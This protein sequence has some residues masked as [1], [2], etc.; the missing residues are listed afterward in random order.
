MTKKHIYF[1]LFAISGFSGLVYESIWTHYLKLFLGHAAYAQMLVL[2]IFMGGM[3]LGSYGSTIIGHRF[4]NLL[5]LYALCEACIGVFALVFHPLFVNVTHFSYSFI[6]Q[7]LPWGFALQSY[8]WALSALL[9][10]PQSMLLGATFPLMSAGLLRRYPENPGRVIAKLYFVNSFG[11][12]IGVLACG[13]FL[14]GAL[15]FLGTIIIAGS[16]NCLLA[17]GIALL[18]KKAFSLD[19]LRLHYFGSKQ[20]LDP[21]FNSYA[22]RANSDFFPTLDLQA[23]K[24]AILGR[25]DCFDK[26][27]DL[28][29]MRL[30][31][32]D[33]LENR[34]LIGRSSFTDSTG[35]PGHAVWIHEYCAGARSS[36][37]PP[38]DTAHREDTTLLDVCT[39]SPGPDGLVG[40]S[41]QVTDRIMALNDLMKICFPIL[42]SSE[43]GDILSYIDSRTRAQA[44]PP[45]LR[46]TLDL[47]TAINKRDFETIDTIAAY[48]LSK[49]ADVT[50]HETFFLPLAMVATIKLKHYGEVEALWN[51]Y[52][53]KENP[54][55]AVRLLYSLAGREGRGLRPVL[56][57]P[58]H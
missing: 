16:I 4:R 1:L 55:I 28:R 58:V 11:G 34:S 41:H 19:D 31:L 56:I 43:V 9:I 20:S 10:L 36:A 14:I 37:H 3:A 51:R 21:L 32:I 22:I 54:E 57:P 29:Y 30:P 2:M 24:T 46:R 6:L 25:N 7:R 47:Y 42:S 48:Y 49:S 40:A 15:G 27:V 33:L 38:I 50:E 8:I 26:L 13:Y 12:A 53:R 18:S 5:L 23:F 39:D 52:G 45:D 35:W 44:L 17:L